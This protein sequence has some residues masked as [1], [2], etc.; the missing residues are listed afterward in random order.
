MKITDETTRIGSQIHLSE[1]WIR[2]RTKMSRILNTASRYNL[3][4]NAQQCVPV[5]QGAAR[6]SNRRITLT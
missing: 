3:I 1:V 2:I 6:D 4:A 5:P